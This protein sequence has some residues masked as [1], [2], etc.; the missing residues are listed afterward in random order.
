VAAT[1]AIR[2]YCHAKRGDLPSATGPQ[3]PCEGDW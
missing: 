2:I 3:E 1:A